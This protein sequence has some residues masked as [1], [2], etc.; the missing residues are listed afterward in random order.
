MS[1]HF[2]VAACALLMAGA[3]SP[4]QQACENLKNL[5]LD[6]ATV[7]TA[8]SMEPGPLKQPAGMPFKVPDV[9]VPLHC[10]VTGVARPT[11]DSEIDITLWL[12][13]QETWN[14]K[15]MQE[16]N[17]GW[18]GSIQPIVL[19]GPL[20]HGYAVAATDDGHR[21]Q[22]IM[23]DASWAIGHPEKLIDFGYRA[24]HETALFSKA[25]LEAYYAKPSTRAYFSGCSDGGREA[26]MEAERY[27]EDF[28]GIIA[29]APANQWTHHFTG[30]LWNE[31]ALNAS[32]AGKLSAEKL[33]AIEKAALSACDALDGVTD[34]LIS[35]PRQCRFDPSILQC[36]GAESNECLTQPQIDT[37]KKI[38]EGPKNPRTG[39]QIYPG[40][41]PGTEAEPGAWSLWILGISAHSLF[42][43]SFF[44]Q[45]VHEQTNWDFHTADLDREMRLAD[46]KTAAIL[47][48]YNPD[49]RSFRDHGGK[50]I[51]YH[52]WGDAAIAP[53]DSIAFYEKVQAF[54]KQY[55][56]P[57]TKDSSD[58]QSFYRLFMVPGM[59]HCTGGPGPPV[60]ATVGSSPER[61]FPT[62]PTTTCSSPSIAG[63]RRASLPTSSSAREKLAPTPRPESR[64]WP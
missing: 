60:S 10:E 26:L 4:A 58:I 22:G 48:S 9:T 6:H 59:Q 34:G 11:S 53:R 13:P 2:V 30:F 40:Y 7:V 14:G 23:P 25:V 55:P 21:T 61:T 24:L 19:F 3:S 52:G 16:G 49:L 44:G 20:M 51:Q 42:A 43:N 18:A 33:P 28:D 36:K 63:S 54:L 8:A 41:E 1:R 29:G 15:Y 50:L 5:K 17:G 32:P 39:E 37:L 57:R 62:M 47:N 35:D 46:A 27:P 12:P 38:Y 31:M 56:D 45:A 64:A